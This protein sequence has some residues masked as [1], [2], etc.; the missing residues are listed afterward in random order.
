MPIKKIVWRTAHNFRVNFTFSISRFLIFLNYWG[1]VKPIMKTQKPFS[2][3]HELKFILYH[4]LYQIWYP[5]YIHA[6]PHTLPD[7]LNPNDLNLYFT[8]PFTRYSELQGF[9]FKLYHTLCQIFC[10][11]TYFT[12]PFTRYSELQG[13]KF[14]L[15]DIISQKH[16]TT[17]F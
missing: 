4:I 2:A 10:L 13:L 14:I 17:R 16:W 3:P 1:N 6:L 12:T 5:A 11:N 8:T 15:Y 7:I 9:K